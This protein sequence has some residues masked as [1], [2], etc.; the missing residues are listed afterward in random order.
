MVV[1]VST[2]KEHTILYVE[3]IMKKTKKTAK[4]TEKKEKKTILNYFE[5]VALRQSTSDTKGRGQVKGRDIDRIND[6]LDSK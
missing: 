4:K 1:L 2:I 6:Y 5:D 3:N